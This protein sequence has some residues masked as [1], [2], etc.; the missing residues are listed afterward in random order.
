MNEPGATIGGPEARV[1]VPAHGARHAAALLRR[2]DRAAR[3]RRSRQPPRL[4][5]RLRAATPRTRSRPAG[6]SGRTT[7]GLRA[8]APAGAAAPRACRLRRGTT[9][10]LLA[11][12]QAYAFA[13]VTES[14]EVAVVVFN[15]D[16]KPASLSVPLAS[17]RLRG[18]NAPR[19]PSWRLRRVARRSRTRSCSTARPLGRALQRAWRL[20]VARADRGGAPG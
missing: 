2:R 5:R 10:Q 18:G 20:E 14:G 16:T 12:E 13:R 9:V 4:P 6:R 19:R 17:T 3:R 1:H 11:T 8:R 15:N 7:G